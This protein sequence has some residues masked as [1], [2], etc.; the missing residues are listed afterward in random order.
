MDL[1]SVRTITDTTKLDESILKL[2]RAYDM[3]ILSTFI[4]YNKR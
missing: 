2:E 3:L 4:G 1:K